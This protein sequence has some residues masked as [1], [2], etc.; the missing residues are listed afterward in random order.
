[1]YELT[2]YLHREKIPYL[3]IR[4]DRREPANT[5]AHFGRQIGLPDCPAFS[6]VALAGKRQSVLILDQ[7]DAICWTSAHSDNALDVCK[8]LER[9]IQLKRLNGDKICIVLSSR[10]FDLENNPA[11]RNW[12]SKKNAQDF[13]RV[14]VKQ[15]PA[16]TVQ[17]LVGTSF[18]MLT[19][20]EKDLLANPL[21][22][23]M[24]LELNRDGIVPRFRTA[25]ALMREFWKDRRRILQEKAGITPAD[26]EQVLTPLID[27]L[28]KN[29][30]ISAP[31]RIVEKWPRLVEAL[32]S[33]GILQQD[34]SRI[35]FC[36]QRYLDYLIA[37]RLL[38]QI[39]SGTGSVLAW[40]GEKKRQSLFHREQLRQALVM[41][42]EEAP[43]KFLSAA[44][45]ILASE[46]VRFHIKHLVLEL[47]G[48]F[49][50][51]PAAVGD[52]CLVLLAD[53]SWRDHVL[54]AVFAGHSQYIL[55]L[56]GKGII[57]QWLD[58]ENEDT[59][60]RVLWLARTV[61]DNI[62][63][64]V[65]DTLAPHL[66][67]GGY[68]PDR[69][70]NALPRK[71]E[72]D[73]ERMFRL[74]L[75]LIRHGAVVSFVNWKALCKEYPLRAIQLIA[76]VLST[77]KVDDEQKTSQRNRIE[78]W[79]DKDETAL[80]TV[81]REYSQET[82]EHLVP[83]IERLT[84]IDAGPYDGR[85]N[86]WQE[87]RFRKGGIVELERGVV[88]LVIVAGRQ[89]A[90]KH[91]DL[92]LARTRSLEESSSQIIQGILIETYGDLPPSHADQGIEW[93]LADTSRFALGTGFNEPQ[94]NPAK[95]LIAALSP[96]CSEKLFRRLEGATVHFHAPNEKRE[97]ECFLKG[98]K[99]GYFG[100]YW[101]KAQYFLLPA[102]DVA[103]VSRA[104]KDLIEVLYRKFA[105]YSEDRFLRGRSW[106]GV[107]GSKLD[108][109]LGKISDRAWLEIIRSPKVREPNR[110]DR[111]Q[112]APGRVLET[113]VRQFSSSFE[114]AIK[115]QPEWFAQL[116]LRFPADVDMAY[117]AAILDG[118]GQ[119]APEA[120][121]SDEI[122]KS[123]RPACVETIEAVL[124]KFQAGEDRE[125]AIFFC[126]LIS[127]RHEEEWSDATLARL[128]HYAQNHSDLEPGKLNIDCNKTAG[129]AT[130]DALF[131]N[132]INCVR[133]VAAGAIRQLLWEHPKLFS[134]LRPA[135][136]SLVRDHHPA[137]RMAAAEMLLPV[138]LNIEKDQAV[139]WYVT[140][141][142][143]DLR[144]AASPRGSEFY[145]YTIPSHLAQIGP[146]IRQMVLSPIDEVA[147][148]WARQVAARWI[149]QGCFAEELQICQAGTIPQR[150]GIAK[151]AARL[152]HT[153]S[154]TE[155]CWKLLR[156][157][158]NDQDK[159]VRDELHHLFDRYPETMDDDACKSFLLEYINSRAFADDPE[160]FI[161][162]LKDFTGSVLF[163]ADTIF[164]ICEAFCSA[165]SGESRNIGT[166]IP[167]AIS[168]TIP[169][170]LRLYEHALAAENNEI[171]NRCLDIWDVLF[172]NRVG[173]TRELTM[174][175]EQ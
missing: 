106:G 40:L 153:S 11:I 138:F 86:K 148:E 149:F 85:L 48:S 162:G 98:W 169:L 20:K 75:E 115:R 166:A 108:P 83:H 82:W 72:I 81:A 151:A 73:S 87:H 56:C 26:I 65:A 131:Q 21:N 34:A 96:Y 140:A 5:T 91:P 165:I 31:Q 92:F 101:G 139:E 167:H 8:E 172:K 90:A 88:E 124:E 111:I 135:I 35:S 95:R 170:L 160:L 144:V 44:E 4:L 76:V 61:A 6:L 122:K 157:L 68:W 89:L 99:D 80:Q 51:V 141:C 171:A 1:M 103:R 32:F 15:L 49:E 58:S 125:A 12:L 74:R 143:E 55:F 60:K 16:E 42:A 112:V 50:E 79:Y 18:S 152:L 84:L 159:A 102:L 37:D 94:W 119:K 129:E 23:S 22:L 63:D 67:K 175:I 158:L 36:H 93:L 116:A 64:V 30:K 10:T 24:W 17:Q 53:V 59:I 47:I 70:L 163:L 161:W 100:H 77:W 39:D 120:S 121:L 52:Y 9:H 117:I 2:E 145:N 45:Q 28:E 66:E 173:I 174:A 142:S 123:W 114:K 78:Q 62:S 150:Q 46:N 146:L 104:T 33:Y 154:H 109:N 156:P 127:K 105:D 133:G 107:V 7:L 128:V 113:S 43:A 164:S 110:E 29:G 118:C 136:E 137:V 130:V 71:T 3:P 13:D 132:T 155:S 126:Y 19:H 97:A 41:L 69:I 168:E 57:G 25:T 54:E 38:E 147:E 134:K 27:Y 14:E